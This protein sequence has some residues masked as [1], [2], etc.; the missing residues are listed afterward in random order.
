M[1]QSLIIQHLFQVN[2][3]ED[4]SRE[5]LETF[6]EEYPSFG[7][8]HYLL[9]RKLQKEDT[10]GFEEKTKLTC[11]YFS[12]PFWLQWLL[13][14]TDVGGQKAV[15]E[16]KA[17]AVLPLEEA[18]QRHV[19]ADAE[20]PAVQEWS[21]AGEPPDSTVAHA[22]ANHE[23]ASVAHLENETATPVENV[24]T[25]AEEAFHVEPAMTPVLEVE[26]GQ[27]EGPSAAEELLRS[28]EQARE[29]RESLQ[30]I[31]THFVDG[32]ETAGEQ[33]APPVAVD[34]PVAAEEPVAAAD[35]ETVTAEPV[36]PVHE[37]SPIRDEEV[38][39]VLDEPESAAIAIEPASIAVEP[40]AP[41]VEDKPAA[42]PA[43]IVFEPLHTIDYFASQ[44]IKFNLE[45][46]PVD[47]LG[48]Q[49][50]S[51]TDWLKIMRRLPQKNR[52]VIP[53]RLAEQA[54]QNFAAHSIEGKEVL[55]EAMA[56]VL[57]KQGM[58]HR[59]RAVYEK[60]SLLNPEKSAYF[61]AKIEQLN[62]H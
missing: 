25:M 35:I 15:S 26:A 40:T 37:E 6:V 55:T 19:E 30:K 38:P 17:F 21:I 11:L 4:V 44:G 51:F 60:L 33:L 49:L 23:E 10:G 5:R 34:V 52:E 29:I 2:S 22:E 32:T 16:T 41:P 46:N 39:F 56:E 3:L 1:H 36:T 45:E 18:T 61:A 47:A 50:K 20:A 31:N 24:V 28:I 27:E 9:S 12:N 59:A 62:I 57:A 7:I 48:K 53:D 8:G 54:I 42:P 43:E 58:R 14:N 13:E